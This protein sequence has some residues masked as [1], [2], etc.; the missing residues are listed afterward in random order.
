MKID[1][2]VWKKNYG[3]RLITGTWNDINDMLNELS[4]EF[5][6]INYWII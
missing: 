1:V 3:F 6:I 2:K 4:E 5:I